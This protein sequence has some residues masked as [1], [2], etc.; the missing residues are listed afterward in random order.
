MMRSEDFAANKMQAKIAKRQ[1]SITPWANLIDCMPFCR[2]AAR[3]LRES[4][5]L[6]RPENSVQLVLVR[7]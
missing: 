5:A 4:S 2:Q 6:Q 1:Q 3:S 7:R